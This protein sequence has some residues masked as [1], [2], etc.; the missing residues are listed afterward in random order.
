LDK[1]VAISR[2]VFKMSEWIKYFKSTDRN[3]FNL[4]LGCR[5]LIEAIITHTPK[6]GKILEVGCGTAL[7]SLIL[8]DYGFE[9]IA[10][11][12]SLEVL[13]YAK[14]KTN[15][16]KN[17]LKF[18]KADILHLSNL[19]SNKYFDTVCSKGVMEHFSDEHII[20]GLMEQ[21]KISKK[22]I[23]HIPNNRNKLTNKHFGD[24]RFL[25]NKKWV[26]LIKKAGFKKVKVVG[27]YDLPRYTFFLPGLFFR[28]KFS[29]WW[30]YFSKH[31]IFICE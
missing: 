22:V 2:N 31:S 28:S 10:S 26:G 14:E 17:H 1:Q 23:F 3:I 9:T 16:G 7:L 25:S 13:N 30:K 6:G 8:A 21:R 24:E 29:F 5:R 4:C 12:V 11:D 20:K 27:D 18:V 19:F 15:I